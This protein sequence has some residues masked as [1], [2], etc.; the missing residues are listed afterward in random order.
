MGTDT[1]KFTFTTTA[2]KYSHGFDLSLTS[3]AEATHGRQE[4]AAPGVSSPPPPQSFCPRTGLEDFGWE[5]NFQ[6]KEKV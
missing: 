6:K 2:L 3:T 4:P 1:M 5:S